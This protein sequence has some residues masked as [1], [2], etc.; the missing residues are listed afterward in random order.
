MKVI[1]FPT[2]FCHSLEVNESGQITD[3]KLRMPDQKR[4]SVKALKDLNFK[5]IAAGDSYND[6][7]MLIE[8]HAGILFKP[9]QNVIAEFQQFPVANSYEE[10]ESEFDK[11]AARLS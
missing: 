2:L 1:D 5:V 8:A 7:S 3:Y 9:P 11:A 10:L 6:T 4:E